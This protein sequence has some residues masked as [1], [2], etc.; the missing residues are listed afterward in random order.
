MKQG[1]GAQFA[2]LKDEQR[3]RQ[4]DHPLHCFAVCVCES[5]RARGLVLGGGDVGACPCVFAA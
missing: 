4:C 2:K 3:E 1:P 5:P